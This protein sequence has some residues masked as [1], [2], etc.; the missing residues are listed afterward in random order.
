MQEGRTRQRTPWHQDQP[1]Y[2]VDGPGVSAWIAVD[3]VPEDGCLELLAGSHR[4]PRLMPRT[5]LNQEARWFPRGQ[6]GRTA[7][8]R[9]QPRR[10]RHPAV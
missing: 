10:L 5:F 4:G 3:P 2:N 1:Y 9:R 6:P 8:H 7:R